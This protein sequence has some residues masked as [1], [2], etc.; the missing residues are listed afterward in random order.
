[1]P[2]IETRGFDPFGG[3]NYVADEGVIVSALRA[4]TDEQAVKAFTEFIRTIERHIDP[5]LDR[6]VRELSLS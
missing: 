5:M 6:M 3:F 2:V 1:M 4:P